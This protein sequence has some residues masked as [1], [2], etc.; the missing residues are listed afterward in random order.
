M[1]GKGIVPSTISFDEN[2]LSLKK[3]WTTVLTQDTD[4]KPWFCSL[5]GCR[6]EIILAWL[7]PG[8]ETAI[9]DLLGLWSFH[10]LRTCRK[11]EVKRRVFRQAVLP[12][13]LWGTASFSGHLEGDW[14]KGGWLFFLVVLQELEPFKTTWHHLW[15]RKFWIKQEVLSV[16]RTRVSR[17]RGCHEM[18]EFLS[19]LSFT[20]IF[21]Q[22]QNLMPK[23]NPSSKKISNF[24]FQMRKNGPVSPMGRLELL[25]D[26]LQRHHVHGLLPLGLLKTH[27]PVLLPS[28]Q[29]LPLACHQTRSQMEITLANHL[30]LDASC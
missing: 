7:W 30:Q 29:I 13:L 22:S 12:R 26:I 14:I 24:F 19:F 1:S 17:L 20:V 25:A 18:T 11:Y 15:P 9:R 21:L 16:Q 2:I 8:E 28:F 4:F 3:N 23:P 10:G 6:D 5:W 27:L